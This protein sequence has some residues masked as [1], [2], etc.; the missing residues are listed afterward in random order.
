MRSS[1]ASPF[2]NS[3]TMIKRKRT[4]EEAM[5]LEPPAFSHLPNELT[6]EILARVAS[7]S[8]IDYFNTKICCKFFNK[9]GE[10]DYVYRHMS[11]GKLKHIAWERRNEAKIFYNTCKKSGHPE[12]LYEEGVMEYFNVKSKTANSGLD[13][14]KRAAN[15]GHQGASYIL[16]IIL[17]CSGEER[18]GI[19]LLSSIKTKSE[20][21]ECRS[22]LCE[23]LSTMWIHKR[24]RFVLQPVLL[25]CPIQH[26]TKKNTGWTSEWC[27][28]DEHESCNRCIWNQEIIYVCNL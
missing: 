5:E 12:V 11:L 27:E 2:I 19:K 16:G 22:K 14:L 4:Y 6:T 24:R 21:K 7:S 1:I 23:V 28:E 8:Q 15:L 10:D 18:K 13:L 20:L 17:I 26:I 25:Y 9:V 3:I